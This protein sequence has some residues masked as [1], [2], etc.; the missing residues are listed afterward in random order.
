MRGKDTDMDGKTR[1]SGVIQSQ[2]QL[3][4]SGEEYWKY[5]LC[6]EEGV[7]MTPYLECRTLSAEKV[8]AVQLQKVHKKTLNH[9]LW[10]FT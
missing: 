5:K 7:N 10:V 9:H 6:E 3:S 1:G 2:E 8:K 4:V